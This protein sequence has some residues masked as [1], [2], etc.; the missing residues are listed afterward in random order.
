MRI[1]DGKI[2]A[3]SDPRLVPSLFDGRRRNR[4][5][6]LCPLKKAEL[7]GDSSHA[8]NNKEISLSISAWQARNSSNI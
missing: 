8:D 2:D 3:L 7:K 4:R 5:G 1:S 6:L